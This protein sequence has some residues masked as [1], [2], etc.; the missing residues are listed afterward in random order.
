MP[1]SVLVD[2]VVQK[3]IAVLKADTELQGQPCGGRI[4]PDVEDT[5]T[6]PVIV[7]SGSTGENTR[8]LNANIV[9]RDA[10]ISVSCRDKGGTSKAKLILMARRVMI[11]LQGLVLQP[12]APDWVYVGK[13]SEARQ[14]PMGATNINGVLY[15]TIHLEFDTKAYR[16]Q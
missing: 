14:R 9:W 13:L 12:V 3:I 16:T 11:V 10:V 5:T 8:T 1:V 4:F 15:P 2:E 6:Y 7:V